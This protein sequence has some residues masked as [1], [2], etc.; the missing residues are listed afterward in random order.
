MDTKRIAHVDRTVSFD[1]LKVWT[2]EAYGRETGVTTGCP[3][4]SLALGI[5]HASREKR[6][7]Q[8]AAAI[9]REEEPP[10]YCCED[11]VAG[12]S[13]DET[14]LRKTV[15]RMYKSFPDETVTQI[16]THKLRDPTSWF[17]KA[18]YDSAAQA[19]R[20]WAWYLYC[21]TFRVE[22]IAK[23][24]SLR[25]P[26]L[27]QRE[28]GARGDIVAQMPLDLVDLHTIATFYRCSITV[29]HL[30]AKS[31]RIK[32]A[33]G[34]PAADR[35]VHLVSH[36][37]L[38]APLLGQHR[39]ETE[40]RPLV[41]ALIE[42]GN[43]P[44][45]VLYEASG[46]LAP[47]LRY[48]EEHETYIAQVG[49]VLLPLE[50]SQIHRVVHYPGEGA[51]QETA[52]WVD[53][54]RKQNEQEKAKDGKEAVEAP[55]VNIPNG[56]LE[57]QVLQ[58]LVRRLA[59]QKLEST[60]A[61]MS[62]RNAP[63][64]GAATPNCLR[65]NAAWNTSHRAYGKED[66]TVAL[67][68]AALDKLAPVSNEG[69]LAGE[70]V[71]QAAV[72]T[73]AAA[74]A[75]ARVAPDATVVQSSTATVDVAQS[76]TATADVAQ[77]SP[78]GTWEPVDG[79]TGRYYWNRATNETAWKLPEITPAAAENPYT[80]PVAAATP[81][82]SRRVSK[83]KSI[84][85]VRELLSRN[86]SIVVTAT[87][88]YIARSDEELAVN[89]GDEVTI[90]HIVGEWAFGYV[91]SVDPKKQAYCPMTRLQVWEVLQAH[92]PDTNYEFY[93]RML[94]VGASE[95]VI[96]KQLYIGEWAGFC[97]GTTWG[98]NG[99]PREGIFPSGKDRL[100]PIFF[101]KENHQNDDNH[102]QYRFTPCRLSCQPY[103]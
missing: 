87:R 28:W 7:S 78:L 15:V 66:S 11:L 71:W 99:A 24:Q 44:G 43:L 48:D 16:L 2:S 84:E 94:R 63:M 89:T 58:E 39:P 52:A 3:W 95:L 27:A 59:R 49:G 91:A 13:F 55:L 5:R 75:S 97:Y 14:E 41:G 93:D 102:H 70:D 101:V 60:Y 10:D 37:G 8:V 72:A 51:D 20:Y 92:E 62:G 23:H 65:A 67:G 56:S 1:L 86:E 42:V 36:M 64:R 88:D 100:K 12:E 69:L 19:K 68:K 18:K 54:R 26:A 33:P 57:F 25:D 50:R 40:L 45:K 32:P 22:D 61:E 29:S 31:Q 79:E 83:R 38:W 73:P 30:M 98:R 74:A 4:H 77:S 80:S 9:A 82:R 53:W 81:S 46:R 103:Q 34:Q 76:S 47:L 85:E 21:L 6:R 96:V 90:Q 35:D 17:H